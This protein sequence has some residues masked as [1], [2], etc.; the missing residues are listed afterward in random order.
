M[1]LLLYG[2]TQGSQDFPE[3]HASRNFFERSLF[4][5]E[6]GFVAFLPGD[7]HPGADQ[8]FDLTSGIQNR[9]A[10]GLDVLHGSI[11]KNDAKFML[12][13]AFFRERFAEAFLKF[14]LIVGMNA[15][16]SLAVRGWVGAGFK[17][18]DSKVLVGPINIFLPSHVPGPASGVAQTL[19]LGQIRLAAAERFIRLLMF[20][21]RANRGD[22]EGEIFGQLH[23]PFKCIFI[24]LA[25]FRRV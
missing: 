15:P 1:G 13:I 3:L 8:F 14:H 17:S 25:G 20:F 10:D 2:I 16:K 19:A 9:V 7:V 6:Q 22:S 4:R 23:V 18:E 11:G 21:P 24:E 5:G 12:E